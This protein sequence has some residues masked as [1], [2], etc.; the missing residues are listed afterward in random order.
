LPSD[1]ARCYT[2]ATTLSDECNGGYSV[3]QRTLGIS[4]L[5]VARP[6][7]GHNH[8]PGTMTPL[9]TEGVTDKEVDYEAFNRSSG[10][11]RTSTSVGHDDRSGFAGALATC[12]EK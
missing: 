11:A 1:G 5:L 7:T 6:T 12:C 9:S 4:A 10:G 3:P 8:R 2:N